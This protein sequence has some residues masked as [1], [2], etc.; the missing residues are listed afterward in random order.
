MWYSPSRV[1][2]PFVYSLRFLCWSTPRRPAPLSAPT[3]RHRPR[4][5]RSAR[6]AQEAEGAGRRLYQQSDENGRAAEWRLFHFRRRISERRQEK[7]VRI[8]PFRR[9]TVV[10]SNQVAWEAWQMKPT[11]F[12]AAATLLV[13]GAICPAGA[14]TVYSLTPLGLLSGTNTGSAT[15]INDA[16]QV[17]GTSFTTTGNCSTGCTESNFNAVIWNGTTPTNLPQ[18]LPVGSAG[19]NAINNMGQEAGYSGDASHPQATV[20]NGTTPTGLEG[21][22]TG[23]VPQ[24]SVA[25]GINNAGVTVGYSYVTGSFVA[26]T[27]WHGVTPTALGTLG[28]LRIDTVD[29]KNRLRDVETDCRNRLHG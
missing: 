17:V 5:L 14:E 3:L 19:A 1:S 20:W 10:T 6:L 4:R 7:D 11:L 29:L 9:R 24:T 25:Y 21:L 28:A 22:A 13:F 2:L 18:L 26:P 23:G 16:G 15:A 8:R 27:V 12:G